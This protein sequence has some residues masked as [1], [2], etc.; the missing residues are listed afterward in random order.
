MYNENWHDLLGSDHDTRPIEE[1]P[2]V[3]VAEDDEQMHRH[4]SSVHEV[5]TEKQVLDL[6]YGSVCL[7]ASPRSHALFTLY[8]EARDAAPRSVARVAKLQLVD[9]AG[10]CRSQRASKRGLEDDVVHEWEEAKSINCSLSYLGQVI[11]ALQEKQ[12]GQRSHIPYRN[13]LL[14]SMLRDSLGGNCKT[15]FVANLAMAS[16]EEAVAT[17]RFAA[18]CRRES[19]DA[20]AAAHECTATEDTA[21]W[22][23]TQVPPPPTA[24]AAAAVVAYRVLAMD[25]AA[26]GVAAAAGRRRLLSSLVALALAAATARYAAKIGCFGQRDADPH[27]VVSVLRAL[28]NAHPLFFLSCAALVD[29]ALRSVRILRVAA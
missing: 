27:R 20:G 6:F 24:C 9:L 19:R 26:G 22:S 8:V 16:P 1:W 23:L 7:A 10:P 3:P 5:A 12:A 14:T 29:G 25:A 4:N 18:R 11:V 2:R 15:V 21:L 17:M 13:S 28:R